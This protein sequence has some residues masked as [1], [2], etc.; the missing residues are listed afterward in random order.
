MTTNVM[1]RAVVRTA[2]HA[3]TWLLLLPGT[4]RAQGLAI[5]TGVNVNP[6]QVAVGGQY[7]FGPIVD[8]V[9]FQP[10]AD[11]GFGNGAKLV[12]VNMDLVYRIPLAKQS[13]WTLFAGG[14]SAL[15]YFKMP[16][17][18]VTL[19][20][21]NVLGGFIAPQRSLRAG[22]GG[23]P[24]QPQI[25]VRNRLHVPPE[26]G[27]AKGPSTEMTWPRAGGRLSGPATKG[28]ERPDFL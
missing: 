4:G 7:E 6:D 26:W 13:P 2:A 5:R 19:A 8:H 22:G 21:A 17:Y 10:N 12:T 18:D 25:Q 27:A 20:G 15:Y 11:F 16:G 9:W 28:S 23:I 3:M 14:G 24:R 1:R